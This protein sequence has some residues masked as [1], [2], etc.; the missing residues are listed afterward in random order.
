MMHPA[1][2]EDLGYLERD[3]ARVFERIRPDAGFVRG[4]EVNLEQELRHL[5]CVR[6]LAY[7]TGALL[8]LATGSAA[9]YLGWRYVRRKR[10]SST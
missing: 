6:T 5:R 8:G 3:L 10:L 7:V 1:D 9:L 4:L 2:F